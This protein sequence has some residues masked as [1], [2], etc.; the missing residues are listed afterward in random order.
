MP[1]AFGLPTIRLDVVREHVPDFLRREPLPA[2]SAGEQHA[3]V[4]AVLREATADDRT[5]RGGGGRG[6]AAV[7]AQVALV[8]SLVAHNYRKGVD[9]Y[10]LRV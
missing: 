2:A 5:R 8:L 7:A 4:A 9:R 3:G 10:Y 6:F 1:P